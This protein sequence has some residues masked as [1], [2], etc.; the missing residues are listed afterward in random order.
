MD[1]EWAPTPSSAVPTEPVLVPIVTTATEMDPAEVA[2]AYMHRWPAQENVIRDWLIPLGLD[3]NHGYSKAPVPNSEVE[4]RRAT[5]EKRL[6]NAKRWGEQA[7]LASLRAH[8]TSSRR[9]KRAKARSREAYSELNDRL[10]ELEAR[11]VPDWEYRTRKRELVAA[12]ETE[13][14]GHW[15]G[16]YRAFNT[17]NREYAKW[18]QYCQNQREILRELEDL[19]A[20]ERRM[21]ELDN[22]KD[23]VMTILKLA[24]ANL[25]MWVRDSYFPP[26]YASATWGRLAPFFRL[27]GRVVWDLDSMSVELRGF[28]DR[29]LNRDLAAVC[30]RVNEAHLRLPNGRALLFGVTS[31]CR[32][33]PRV[34]ERSAA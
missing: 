27:P 20:G 28:N 29:A 4:K 2:K 34:W 9:W 23:Q 32:H 3:T 31:S 16:Y 24:L 7:R 5:L 22:R 15:R 14:E 21:Y 18:E 13:M 12:V 1:H 8:K 10:S 6:E 19:K 17:C 25:A 26:E 30:T 33:G 11:G